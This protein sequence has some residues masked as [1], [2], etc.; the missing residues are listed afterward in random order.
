MTNI[1]LVFVSE[2][3]VYIFLNV[4][5]TGSTHCDMVMDFL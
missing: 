2:L 5:V 4:E 3:L 1:Y